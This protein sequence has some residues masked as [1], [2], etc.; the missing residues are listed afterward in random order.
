MIRIVCCWVCFGTHSSLLQSL[1][2]YVFLIVTTR[3]CTSAKRHLTSK[4]YSYS[5][6]VARPYLVDSGLT[7]HKML[8]EHL[9]TCWHP[10]YSNDNKQKVCAPYI[11]IIHKSHLTHERNERYKNKNKLKG[12]PRYKYRSSALTACL[13]MMCGMCIK[14][15]YNIH[16][17]IIFYGLGLWNK[18]WKHNI[19]GHMGGCRADEIVKWLRWQR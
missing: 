12:K 6:V 16:I 11:I 1:R 18:N 2:L 3:V 15:G 10:L 9:V 7:A 17:F 14:V 8:W 5:V 4:P 19:H 13:T